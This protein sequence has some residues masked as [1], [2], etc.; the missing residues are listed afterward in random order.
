MVS[1]YRQKQSEIFRKHTF[2]SGCATFPVSGWA[3]LSL[4]QLRRAECFWL[5][6]TFLWLSLAKVPNVSFMGL[7]SVFGGL[8]SAPSHWYYGRFVNQ[9]YFPS[10]SEPASHFHKRDFVVVPHS[11]THL[12]G[13]K[14]VKPLWTTHEHKG[15]LA[16]DYLMLA[17]LPSRTFCTSQLPSSRGGQESVS[18]P[19]RRCVLSRPPASGGCGAAWGGGSGSGGICDLAGRPSGA[20]RPDPSPRRG[21]PHPPQLT[22]GHCCTGGFHYLPVGSWCCNL[23]NEQNKQLRASRHRERWLKI[24]RARGDVPIFVLHACKRLQAASRRQSGL[25]LKRSSVSCFSSAPPHPPTITQ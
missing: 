1:R 2:L 17:L 15:S 19:H 13:S 25:F 10:I 9:A 21:S 14:W 20:G 7:A 12:T 4:F 5:L 6:G 23:E 22:R 11:E 8:P 16:V 18:T 24:S 3:H